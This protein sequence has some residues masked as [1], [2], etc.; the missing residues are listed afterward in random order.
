MGFQNLVKGG[1]REVVL[2]G[3]V[4][5]EEPDL[6]WKHSTEVGSKWERQWEKYLQLF[7]LSF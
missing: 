4:A 5:M 2:E 7:L 6:S 1:A 3:A